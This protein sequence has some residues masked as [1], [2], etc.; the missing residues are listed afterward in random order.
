MLVLFVGLFIGIVFF[1]L[2]GS[3][4][5]FCLYS[6]MNMDVEKFKMI[7]KFG[8]MKKELKKMIY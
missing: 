3:F 7:Y 5:Y 2:V 1:V 4:L 8:L 6:D